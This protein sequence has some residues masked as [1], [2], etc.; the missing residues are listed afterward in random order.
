M[1]QQRFDFAP[2]P[3]EEAK[4]IQKWVEQ[5]N[6][7]AI[8]ASQIPNTSPGSLLSALD[9]GEAKANAVYLLRGILGQCLRRAIP[10][11]ASSFKKGFLQALRGEMAIKKTNQDPT[12]ILR[13]ILIKIHSPQ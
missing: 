8:I 2:P 6:Q 3:H 7:Q 5:H 12:L 1:T 11:E 13:D 10:L 4:D 9:K